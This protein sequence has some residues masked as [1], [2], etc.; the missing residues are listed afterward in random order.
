MVC[1]GDTL[2]VG[3]PVTDAVVHFVVLQP[4]SSIATH[5]YA[6][7]TQRRTMKQDFKSR[8][9]P[10]KLLRKFRMLI[11]S[12]QPFLLT[13]LSSFWAMMLDS[14]LA[15]QSVKILTN[16]RVFIV[17]LQS[18]GKRITHCFPLPPVLLISFLILKNGGIKISS[19]LD[20]LVMDSKLKA[21]WQQSPRHQQHTTKAATHTSSDKLPYEIF[22]RKQK[23]G[24][25]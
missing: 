7:G 15:F 24:C 4:S 3:A 1:E 25:Q 22:H 14:Q 17:F 13:L 21:I 12:P 9:V 18:A 2:R 5:P 10:S 20:V 8:N 6:A 11:H 16:P 19:V 23:P